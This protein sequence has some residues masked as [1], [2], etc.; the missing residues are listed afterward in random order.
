MHW[1]N[2]SLQF[3]L[4]SQGVSSKRKHFFYFVSL[5]PLDFFIYLF[6]VAFSPLLSF[7]NPHSSGQHLGAPTTGLAWGVGF[8]AW[9]EVALFHLGQIMIWIVLNVAFYWDQYGFHH[10]SNS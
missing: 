2:P 6:H 10:D 3:C 4:Q 9:D 5:Y 7:L 8:L 1:F